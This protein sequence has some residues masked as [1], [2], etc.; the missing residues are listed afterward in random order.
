MRARAHNLNG[1]SI[2]SAVFAQMTVEY[3]YTLEWDTHFSKKLPLP[4]GDLDFLNPNGVSIG[5][6]VFCRDH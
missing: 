2:G 3:P 5:S 4:I 6:A 1:I